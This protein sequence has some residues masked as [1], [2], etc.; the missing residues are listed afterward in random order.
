MQ[1]L[2]TF[3]NELNTNIVSVAIYADGIELIAEYDMKS[4]DLFSDL[5][6]KGVKVKSIDRNKFSIVSNEQNYTL[7]IEP[8]HFKQS[9]SCL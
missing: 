9:I 1:R 2:K 6:S 7:I 5:E 3:L 8:F 4:I